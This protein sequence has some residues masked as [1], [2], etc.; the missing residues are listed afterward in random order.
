MGHS[1]VFLKLD[2]EY[3]SDDEIIEA[4]PL[5]ELLFIRGLVF[6]KRKKLDGVISK[7]Q[8]ASVA[9]GIPNATKH[10]RALVTVGLWE[11]TTDGWTIP[12]WLKHNKSAAELDADKEARRIASVEA[13]HAQHHVGPGKKRSPKCELCR[14]ETAPKSAPND[15]PKSE[16]DRTRNRLQEAEGEAEAEAEGEPK[17]EA[18]ADPSSSQLTPP[19]QPPAGDDGTVI[20]RIIEAVATKRRDEFCRSTDPNVRENYLT[21]TITRL[22]EHERSAIAELLTERPHMANAVELAAEFY[23]AGRTAS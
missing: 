18:E 9:L 7:S 3:A 15:A 5:P 17:G 21:K 1:G 2:A 11:Q 12:S 16:Q 6:C 14:A 19:P 10:A 20:N 8:L 13:N 4:G 23:E 22:N